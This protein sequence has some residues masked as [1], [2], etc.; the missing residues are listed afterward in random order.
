MHPTMGLA[1]DLFQ[2]LSDIEPEYLVFHLRLELEKWVEGVDSLS[3]EWEK[4]SHEHNR[5]RI[6]TFFVPT[7]STSKHLLT[8]PL[9]QYAGALLDGATA[10]FLSS[11]RLDDAT[12]ISLKG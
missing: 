12:L 11:I 9:H 5:V 1:P 4:Y 3:V 10:S 7:R 8:F 6:G 2:P